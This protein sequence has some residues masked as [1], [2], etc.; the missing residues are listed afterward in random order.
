MHQFN[1]RDDGFISLDKNVPAPSIAHHCI[2][3]THQTDYEAQVLGI[4]SILPHTLG[5]L[6]AHPAIAS[7]K[8]QY[9]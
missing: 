8:A 1:K 4:V 3:H 2:R 7:N 6:F 9:I 5:L